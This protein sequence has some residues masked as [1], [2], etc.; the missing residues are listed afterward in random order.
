MD[1]QSGKEP[2]TTIQGEKVKV[3]KGYKILGAH[4]N[5]RLDW[6]NSTEIQGLYKKGQNRLC[7]TSRLRSFNASHMLL[8]I[9]ACWGRGDNK[10]LST[11]MGKT[12]P[13]TGHEQFYPSTPGGAILKYLYLPAHMTTVQS[14][15]G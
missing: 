1:F 13:I 15:T 5:S 10:R 2:C 14:A 6:A 11:L 3:V 7:F 12:S 8:C 4:L 9:M